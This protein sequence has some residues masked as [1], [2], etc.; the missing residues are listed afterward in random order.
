V[1]NLS[2]PVAPHAKPRRIPVGKTPGKKQIT[3]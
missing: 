1:L 3:S 2:I